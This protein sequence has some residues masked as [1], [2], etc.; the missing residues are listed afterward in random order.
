MFDWDEARR[1]EQLGVTIA[2]HTHRHPRL[3][4]LGPADVRDELD[5]A[6]TSLHAHLARPGE[7][8][9]YPF[10][11]HDDE[12]GALVRAA[13]HVGAC[14]VRPGAVTPG[15]PPFELPRHTVA[16]VEGLCRFAIATRF[17]GLPSRIRS[18]RRPGRTAS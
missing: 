5:T 7:V 17:G 4:T 13:G 1:L 11:D 12:T 2:S 14:T 18:R 3:T 8:F 9:A 6:R 15:T 16:G 10:G